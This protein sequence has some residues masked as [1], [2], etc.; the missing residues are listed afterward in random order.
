MGPNDACLAPSLWGPERE[1]A[2]FSPDEA[3]VG[4]AQL[5]ASAGVML[6]HRNDPNLDP[7]P[8]FQKIPLWFVQPLDKLCLHEHRS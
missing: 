6:K 7:F 1:G 5:A 2:Y 8:T 4:A 3:K